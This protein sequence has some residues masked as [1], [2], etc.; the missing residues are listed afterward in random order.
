MIAADRLKSP[1][2]QFRGGSLPAMVLRLTDPA[3]PGLEA[4][5]AEQVGQAPGFYEGVA[6]L[7]DLAELAMHPAPP[8]VDFA[9]LKTALERL[10]LIPIGVQGGTAHLNELARRA[11]L[12]ALKGATARANVRVAETPKAPAAPAPAGEAPASGPAAAGEAEK[13]AASAAAAD[14]AAPDRDVARDVAGEGPARPPA[15]P[16]ALKVV[17]P[18]TLVVTEPVRS[19]QQVYARDA[20]LI[21]CATVNAGAEILADGHIH[22][23]GALRG[24]ALAGVAGDKGARV[25]CQKFDPE[26]VSIAGHY[27]IADQIEPALVGGRVMVRVGDDQLAFERLP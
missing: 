10:G 11:G 27:R 18:K 14:A 3:R 24:K 15:A 17:R 4:R 9:P 7:L 5:L 2:F 8:A 6:V 12:P 1:P 21:V 20:D 19:G 16:A 13:A 23:Y 26:L 22:V 25:F